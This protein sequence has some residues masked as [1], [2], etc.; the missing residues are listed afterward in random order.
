VETHHV[1]LRPLPS[2]SDGHDAFHL[3][4]FSYIC[5]NHGSRSVFGVSVGFWYN[6][7]RTSAWSLLI[8]KKCIEINFFLDGG[9]GNIPPAVMYM[10]STGS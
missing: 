7:R 5:I 4:H 8:V 2:S 10:S 1:S 9:A 3:L 6:V